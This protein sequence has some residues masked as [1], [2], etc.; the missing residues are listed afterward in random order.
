M[1]YW[2]LRSADYMTYPTGYSNMERNTNSFVLMY[3]DGTRCAALAYG[4]AAM[5]N[6]GDELVV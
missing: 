5:H 3:T 1:M 6:Y 2:W 4:G